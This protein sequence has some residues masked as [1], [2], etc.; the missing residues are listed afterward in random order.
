[1]FSSR[2]FVSAFAVAA[3]LKWGPQV[4]WINSLGLLQHITNVPTWFTHDLTVTILGLLAVL[5]IVA[6]KSSD[7]RMLLNEVDGYIK[8]ASAFVTTFTVAGIISANDAAVIK[9]ITV[10]I[11]PA[12]CRCS[13]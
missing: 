12:A 4:G 9:Q 8:S 10:W 13:V 1:M 6:T 5:E 2:A 3:M 7:A 11:D